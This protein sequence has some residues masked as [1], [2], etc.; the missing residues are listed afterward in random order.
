MI[1]LLTFISLLTLTVFMAFT[2]SSYVL[3]VSYVKVFLILF[4][5]MEL[6]KA[7]LFWKLLLSGFFG[8]MCLLS[9]ALS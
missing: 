1:N 4:V 5:Y 2:T 9:V 7:H 8:I 6:S 3:L